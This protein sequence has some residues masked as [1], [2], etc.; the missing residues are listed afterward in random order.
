MEAT[1]SSLTS[2]YRFATQSWSK[3]VQL[4]ITK[5]VLLKNIYF[6][7]KN[8]VLTYKKLS[9]QDNDWHVVSINQSS[10]NYANKIH[11]SF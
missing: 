3:E 1:E 7:N 4:T 9:I 11:F 8:V 2:G 10:K 6:G 5:T